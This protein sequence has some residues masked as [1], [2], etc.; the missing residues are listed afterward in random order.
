MDAFVSIN[1]IIKHMDVLRD[2]ILKAKMN[3][4]VDADRRDRLGNLETSIQDNRC[5]K[6]T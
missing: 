2:H 1:Q 5:D 3:T 6:A 4:M